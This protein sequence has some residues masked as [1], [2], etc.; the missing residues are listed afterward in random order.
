MRKRVLTGILITLL[1]FVVARKISKNRPSELEWTG[2]G[3][4]ITHLTIYEHI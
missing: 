2:G 1:I 4:K 3:V